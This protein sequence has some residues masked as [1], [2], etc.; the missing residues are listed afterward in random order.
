[1]S[2]ILLLAFGRLNW[3]LWILALVMTASQPALANTKLDNIRKASIGSNKTD[4]PQLSE[5]EFPSTSA[6][7]LVKSPKLS[8]NPP[9]QEE[10]K[11]EIVSITEVKAN[12]TDKGLELILQTTQARQLKVINRSCGNICS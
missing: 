5:I 12:P 11:D 2:K 3:R 10:K 4:I 6:R 7:M 1:M 8:Q 9:S